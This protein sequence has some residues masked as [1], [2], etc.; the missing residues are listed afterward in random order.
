MWGDIGRSL[1][2]KN[3]PKIRWGVAPPRLRPKAD[4]MITLT[5]AEQLFLRQIL[6]EY[7]ESRQKQL[8]RKNLAPITSQFVNEEIEN[9][10]KLKLKLFG[11]CK[12]K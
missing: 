3:K 2:K 9:A 1:R 11:E 10:T 8:K 12:R 7:I 6:G 5:I 4:I